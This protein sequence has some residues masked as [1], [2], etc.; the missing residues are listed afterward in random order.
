MI[1]LEYMI[2]TLLKP[3]TQ[4]SLYPCI[5]R[6]YTYS[7]LILLITYLFVGCKRN[8]YNIKITQ[9]TEDLIDAYCST[10]SECG[11]TFA[12]S[13]GIILRSCSD[14]TDNSLLIF[15]PH[16]FNSYYEENFAGYAKSCKGIMVKVFGDTND[17][18]FVKEREFVG[19]KTHT[20]S[21]DDDIRVCC[22][23]ISKD[24]IVIEGGCGT[25]SEVA[26]FIDV[27]RKYYKLPITV[28]NIYDYGNNLDLDFMSIKDTLLE[29]ND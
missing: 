3:V 9:I 4:G 25:F 14:N 5:K 11:V 24:G 7:L 1:N 17:L 23:S 29:H 8:I 6:V 26:P 12:E 20:N 18:F 21:E 19:S 27:C 10:V 13:G 2:G 22:I 28:K 16:D 15:I